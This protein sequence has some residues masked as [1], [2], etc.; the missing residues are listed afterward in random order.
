M[1]EVASALRAVG[2]GFLWMEERRLELSLQMDKERM[3][4]EMEL[5]LLDS[6]QLFVSERNLGANDRS[7]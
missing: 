5:S 7:D 2:E 1:V 6:Q 3:E 4:S